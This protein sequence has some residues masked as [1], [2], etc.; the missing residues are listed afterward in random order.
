MRTAAEIYIKT[1]CGLAAA[2]CAPLLHTLI[3]VLSFR[4][5]FTML[6]PCRSN[7]LSQLLNCWPAAVALW[8]EIQLL[9]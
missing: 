9:L 2:E 6:L 8:M 3:T 1:S 4:S 7:L 5:V